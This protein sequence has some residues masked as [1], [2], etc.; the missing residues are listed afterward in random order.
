[1]SDLV[2]TSVSF[3][4]LSE[5]DIDWYVAT[6]EPDDKAGA[7]GMQGTGN[8]FVDRIDGNPSN[9]IGLP[10]PTV[11]ALARELGVQLLGG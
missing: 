1:M 6:G 5:A 8:V 10:L 4:D 7:Y 2:R 3:S 11:I 9:V